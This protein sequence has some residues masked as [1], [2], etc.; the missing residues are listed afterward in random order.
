MAT[1][2]LG[3]KKVFTAI[4]F[5]FTAIAATERVLRTFGGSRRRQRK[6]HLYLR[7]SFS[8]LLFSYLSCVLLTIIEFIYIPR[9]LNL[10][11]SVVGYAICISGITL[12]NASINALGEEWSLHIDLK[13]MNSIVRTGPYRYLKH[14][15]YAAVFCEL[16]GFSLIPNAYYSSLTVLALQL[17]LLFCRIRFEDRALTHRFGRTH[18]WY[19]RKLGGF[20]F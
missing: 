16:F 6:D 11:I 3:N 4:F 14:P 5:L 7:N 2:F 17:P 19:K 12:R 13:K 15:Y 1:E 8:I 18:A 10:G 9:T 20:P